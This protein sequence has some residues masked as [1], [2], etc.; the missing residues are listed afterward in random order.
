MRRR[1]LIA[2]IIGALA[3]L[4]ALAAS[5]FDPSLPG[6]TTVVDVPAGASA[7]WIAALLEQHGVV[8][9]KALFELLVRAG[10]RQNTLRAGEYRFAA[11]Q[12]PL[13]ILRQLTTE[14]SQVAIWITIPEGYTSREIAH[15][16]LAVHGIGSEETFARFFT[17]ASI[18]IDGQRT[19]NLEGYLFP[20]TYLVPVAA[21]PTD[22]A[23]MMTD[24]F[25]HE[26][27]EDAVER[28]RR[29]GLTI[30]QVVTIASMVER[31]AQVDDERALMAGV[32][33]N[34]LRLAMPLQVDATLEYAFAGGTAMR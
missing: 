20:S 7:S 34:R 18:E 19:A 2:A 27:P 32:Y 10:R 11:H 3:V 24:Q 17:K 16:T 22:V 26:L 28:A 23:Q 6:E 13:S 29:A 1:W 25:R 30:P 33:E 31:E 5:L 15:D 8:R 14:G 9:S 12:T 21:T 4:G